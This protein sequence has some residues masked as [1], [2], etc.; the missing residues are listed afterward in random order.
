MDAE[1]VLWQPPTP[2]STAHPLRHPRVRA[3]ISGMCHHL[4]ELVNE[5]FD[6]LIDTIDHD[7][8]DDADSD[9]EVVHTG[10]PLQ[11]P[12]LAIAAHPVSANT[13]VH[14]LS[15]TMTYDMARRKILIGKNSHVCVDV[16][17]PI[18]GHRRNLK[19]PDDT[20]FRTKFSFDVS[21][22]EATPTRGVGKHLP[23]YHKTVPMYMTMTVDAPSGWDAAP[24]VAFASSSCF[25]D[26]VD[27][28]CETGLYTRWWHEYLAR[29]VGADGDQIL[30]ILRQ[31]RYQQGRP[32]VAYMDGGV[33]LDLNKCIRVPV[34]VNPSSLRASGTS[35]REAFCL[36]K[37]VSTCRGHR[38]LPIEILSLIAEFMCTPSMVSFTTYVCYSFMA[39]C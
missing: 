38:R 37:L 27:L 15:I 33:C 21:P 36:R 29:Q 14:S 18:H 12:K 8:A 5:Y 4:V 1:L 10:T 6:E 22:D 25:R 32:G 23:Q 34:K 7:D 17:V 19:C 26:G 39:L 11:L 9:M 28:E 13:Y 35:R 20:T 3:K 16:D 31:Q 24:C 2:A 30:H